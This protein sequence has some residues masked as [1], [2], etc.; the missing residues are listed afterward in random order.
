MF[1]SFS[2]SVRLSL[3]T[4]PNRHLTENCFRGKRNYKKI[5][6]TAPLPTPRGLCDGFSVES[7][8]V[9]SCVCARK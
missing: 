2:R 4:V 3:G 1:L 5:K 6:S 9:F 8:Q 7:N